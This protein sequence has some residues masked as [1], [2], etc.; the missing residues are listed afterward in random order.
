M[1]ISWVTRSFLDYRIPVYKELN[2]LCGD[3]LTVVYYSDVV[4]QRC[5]VKLKRILKERSIGLTGEIRLIGK[6]LQ[7]VSSL[8]NNKSRIPFQPGLVKTIASSKPEFI[9]SDGFFQWTYGALWLRLM[10]RIPHLM[11]YE[12]TIHTERSINGIKHFYRKTVLKLIDHIACNGSLSAS[13]IKSLGYPEKKI[14][15]G[16][17]AADMLLLQKQIREFD[18]FQRKTLKIKLT[19]SDVVFL[20][21]GRL[22]PLKGVG[23]LIEAWINCFGNNRATS[24]LFVGDGPEKESLKNL[25]EKNGISN[26]HLTGEIDFDS[27][28]QYLAISDIFV[29][30]TLRDNWSLVVPEAMS[31]GLPIICSKY[32]G[33]WPELVKPENG[34]VF[35]PLDHKNFVDT[36]R[37]AWDK[38]S[39]WKEMG[40]QSLELVQNYS[41][42]KVAGNIYNACLSVLK[43]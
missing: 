5:Q 22:V 20:F 33:C 15:H 40:Q 23:K 4:P 10:R 28:Y 19:L 11:C 8:K 41:P 12:G 3:E 39:H 34:W 43:K 9:I 14:S 32:N 6:K 24:L 26:I 36:L 17:M 18:I 1:R 16:N 30:P 42:E 37:E 2:R 25:I 38:R 27:I 7:P 31:A 21:I 13:Y 29:M 35:D